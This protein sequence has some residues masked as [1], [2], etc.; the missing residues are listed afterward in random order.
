M[1]WCMKF[2]T[3]KKSNQLLAADRFLLCKNPTDTP[4]GASPVGLRHWLDFFNKTPTTMARLDRGCSI[5]DVKQ[6]FA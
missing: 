6:F 1:F 5:R 4:K 2:W 3:I